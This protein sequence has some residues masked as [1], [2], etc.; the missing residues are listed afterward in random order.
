MKKITYACVLAG[1]FCW[2]LTCFNAQEREN[3]RRDPPAET[4]FREVEAFMKGSKLNE[5]IVRW[6][7]ELPPAVQKQII[8]ML[9]RNLSSEK[10]LSVAKGPDDE[11]KGVNTP[12]YDL[13]TVRGRSGWAIEQLL[14]CDLSPAMFPDDK[15]GFQQ[16]AYEVVIERMHLPYDPYPDLPKMSVAQRLKLA[17]EETTSEVVLD[18]FVFDAEIEIRLAAAKNKR[19][20]LRALS[21]LREDFDARVRA[22]ALQNSLRHRQPEIP[23]LQEAR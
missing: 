11:G 23:G 7:A 1:G 21:Q 22:A 18:R 9:L 15:T 17:T 16:Y 20:S 2:F 4:A 12:R 10:K 3:V 8:L 14:E 19:T 6:K 5:S 13:F